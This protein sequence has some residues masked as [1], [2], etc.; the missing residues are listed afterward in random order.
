MWSKMCGYVHY[1]PSP[2]CLTEEQTSSYKL[3]VGLLG[4]HMDRM[5]KMQT[6]TIEPLSISLY[7]F[8]MRVT[9]SHAVCILG[10]TISMRLSCH[11]YSIFIF[12]VLGEDNKVLLIYKRGID[13]HQKTFLNY[14]VF[15]GMLPCDTWH[16]CGPINGI[17][18]CGIVLLVPYI[19]A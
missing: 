11:I 6:K 10:G 4:F 15:F 9:P 1:G 13:I 16:I 8:P 18:S 2:C 5:P 17:E 19:H 3:V 7:C 14:F 12:W